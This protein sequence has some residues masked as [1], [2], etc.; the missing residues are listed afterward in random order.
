LSEYYFLLVR[1]LEAEEEVFDC[2]LL[3]ICTFEGVSFILL[4]SGI[5]LVSCQHRSPPF[6]SC[7]VW[8]LTSKV[9]LTSKIGLTYLGSGQ[10]DVFAGRH[11]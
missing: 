8:R 5:L 7:T 4:G 2:Q 11:C 10:Y 9:A 3:L 6:L 1:I